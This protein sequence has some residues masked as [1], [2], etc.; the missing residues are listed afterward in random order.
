MRVRAITLPMRVGPMSGVT[1]NSGSTMAVMST[2]SLCT[3]RSSITSCACSR[4]D[5]EEAA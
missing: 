3:P 1:A 2:V 5:G 4:L